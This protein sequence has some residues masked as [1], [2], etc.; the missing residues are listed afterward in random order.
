MM[1]FVQVFRM[2]VIIPAGER[3]SIKNIL[4]PLYWKSLN[5]LTAFSIVSSVQTTTLGFLIGWEQCIKT[6][7]HQEG[8]EKWKDTFSWCVCLIYGQWRDSH[9]MK[10]P[11]RGP[12]AAGWHRRGWWEGVGWVIVQPAW[13]PRARPAFT[14]TPI[15]LEPR[16][17]RIGTEQ[18]CE[19]NLK[20]EEDNDPTL[21]SN[22]LCFFFLALCHLTWK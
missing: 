8:Q 15:N 14:K 13:S 17:K 19:Q 5:T 22:V 2:V 4:L 18:T 9:L 6:T 16:D 7:R 11:R 3:Y 21:V 20:L 10:S 12:A 1:S